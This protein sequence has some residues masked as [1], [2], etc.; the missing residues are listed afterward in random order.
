MSLDYS[1]KCVRRRSFL[2]LMAIVTVSFGPMAHLRATAAEPVVEGVGAS[3]DVAS[4]ADPAIAFE[5]NV[6]QYDQRAGFA[7]R[8]DDATL[9]LT[10]SGSVLSLGEGQNSAAV[11]TEFSG[12]NARAAFTGEGLLRGQVSYFVGSDSSNWISAV[13][14]FAS[15]RAVD[16]YPGIDVVYHSGSG[17]LEYDFIVSPEADPSAVV[18][19]FDG[20]R[21]MRLTAD[22]DLVLATSAGDLFHRRPVS[23]QDID[24]RRVPV[25]SSFVVLGENT[26][27]LRIGAYDC[28]HSLVIDP[29]IVYSSFLG[30]SNNDRAYGIGIDAAGNTYIAGRTFSPDFP[31]LGGVQ[32]F[33][34]GD[35][36]AFV[37]KFDTSGST[38]VY[39]TY[40]GGLGFDEAL[41]LAVT[42]AGEVVIG[43]DTSSSDFPTSVPFQAALGGSIDGFVARLSSSGS[44]LLFSSYCGGF[45][46]E[47]IEAVS[48][49]STGT[50]SFGGSTNSD[51]TFPLV[52]PLQGTYGGGSSDGI[53]GRVSSGGALLNS[54][55]IGGTGSE[56]VDAIAVDLAGNVYMTGLTQN[57]GFPTVNPFQTAGGSSDAFVT[58]VAADFLSLVYSSPLG[59]GND[60]AGTGIAVDD[61]GNAYITGY[62]RSTNFPTLNAFQPA[63]DNGFDAFVTKVNAAGSAR[64]YS[65]YLGGDLED[66]G[67]AID[68]DETGSV[69]VVGQTRSIDF[70]TFSPSQPA[71]GGNG[72]NDAFVTRIGATG[73]QL[74]YSTYLGGSQIDIAQAVAIDVERTAYVSGYSSSQNFPVLNADQPSHAGVDDAFVTRIAEAGDT[75]GIVFQGSTPPAWFLRNA[76]SSGPA[77][78]TISYG[79]SNASWVPLAGDWDGNGTDTPGLYN[80]ATGTFFL[81]NT[82]TNGPANIVFSFGAPMIYLPIAGDWNGDGI[83]T[84]GI[85][86]PSTGVYFL[87]NTNAAGASDHGFTFGVGGGVIPVAGDWDGNGSDSVGFYETGT[88]IW[89]LRNNLSNGPADFT[90]S[91]GPGGFAPVTGDWNADGIDTPGI[92]DA[93][94]GTWFLRNTNTTGT[95]DVVFG[96]GIGAGSPIAGD[97]NG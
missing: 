83:D 87:R 88:G 91:F 65:S 62:T 76:Q 18:M 38:M 89:F 14:R 35:Y 51:T 59:G 58:K 31:V 21:R 74:I 2:L 60:D 94:N 42:P 23:Y 97:W 80:P 29:K 32:A 72:L 52:L 73:R 78:I 10:G 1:S 33:R 47:T 69:V 3:T 84:I 50:V 45:N 49:D 43:G 64:V 39:S 4:V 19:R 41:A 96:F 9:F 20:V 61:A 55:F 15:V 44:V 57:A 8:T 48:V 11:R 67:R 13:D 93:A 85:F 34:A 6:G 71:N 81:R 86:N 56:L 26:V 27:G 5:R 95:A 79:P 92:Y 53:Y 22:G 90:F 82:S 30:G 25:S 37:T 54:S 70:R 17:D 63:L 24:G 28:A 16:V 77:D 36:D 75:P 66:R 68:V 46:T 40:L 7:A 12:G